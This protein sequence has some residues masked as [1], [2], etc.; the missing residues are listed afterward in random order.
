[1]PRLI[2]LY[3][4]NAAIGFALAGLFVA[5]LMWFDVAHLRHLIATSDKGWLA[6]LVLWVLN[7]IVFAGVQFGIAVMR[8]KDD[9]ND[10][11][12]GLRQHALRPERVTVPVP[13][14]NA[15]RPF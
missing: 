3:I 12:G 13:A 15:R 9:D 8:M 10:R 4:V 14:E 5:M 7:G 1:M 6:L 11:H 2:R